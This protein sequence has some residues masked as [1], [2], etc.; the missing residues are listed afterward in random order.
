MA[1]GLRLDTLEIRL[2]GRVM[3]ALDAHVAPGEVLTVM[4]PSGSGKSTLLAAITGALDPAFAL[5]GRIL[6]D[7]E[8]VTAL[9]TERRR[10]GILFQDELLF[11]HLSVGGNLAFG[12]PPS[13]RG[14]AARRARI[15]RALQEIGLE[16][17]ARRDPATLSGGQKARVAL[18]RTLLAEPRALLLDEPFSRLDAARRGQV[19]ELV[20]ARAKAQRLPVLLVTHDREDAAASGGAV[21]ELDA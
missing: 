3:V 8:D 10:I 14:R 16:G 17:F 20:F 13:L 15:E 19:R 7:G 1:D 12:L 5:S 6:L 18:M 11:P 9:P 2:G 21:I 4:G